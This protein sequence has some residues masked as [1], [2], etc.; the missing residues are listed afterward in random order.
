MIINRDFNRTEHDD[1][2]LNVVPKLDAGNEAIPLWGENKE[3]KMIV[4]GWKIV[5]R[6]E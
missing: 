1:L 4:V 5:N 2:I 3:N 6:F